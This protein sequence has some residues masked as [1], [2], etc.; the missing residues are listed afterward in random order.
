M[1]AE[2][3][4]VAVMAI[5]PETRLGALLE[6]YPQ[7]EALLM[8][9]SPAF[10]RLRNPFLRQTVGKVATLRQIAKIGNLPLIDLINRLRHTAGIDGNY[11]GSEDDSSPETEPAWFDPA[12]VNRSIDARPILQ[13]GGQPL[14]AVSAELNRLAAGTILELI[15]PFPPAPLLGLAAEKGIQTW[16]REMGP[17]ELHT[18][19]TKSDPTGQ[20]INDKKNQ[21]GKK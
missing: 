19:F 3:T 17:G 12:K 18:F 13:A 2:V 11:Q 9:M 21:R 15:T 4:P 7:L 14:A 6:R 5:T 16:T 20:E 8:E 1:N 10:A